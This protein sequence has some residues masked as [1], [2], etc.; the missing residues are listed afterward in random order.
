[1]VVSNETI[2]IASIWFELR[3]GA[4]RLDDF[5]E[6]VLREATKVSR[7]SRGELQAFFDNGIRLE[8]SS[9]RAGSKAP[10]F[11]LDAIDHNGNRTGEVVQLSGALD[12]G[13]PRLR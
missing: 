5:P 8:K 2:D 7:Q 12:T 3:T 1:M 10:D 11:Q 13:W 9:P 4:K 6:G